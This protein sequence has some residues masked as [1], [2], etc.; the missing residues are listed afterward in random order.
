MAKTK[1]RRDTN[2][3][4]KLQKKSCLDCEA[5]SSHDFIVLLVKRNATMNEGY[6]GAPLVWQSGGVEWNAIGE[7]TPC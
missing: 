4:H 5:C 3:K 7:A 2:Q 6:D 1:V